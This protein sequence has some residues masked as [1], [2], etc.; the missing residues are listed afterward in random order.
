MEPREEATYTY[1]Q[2]IEM[3]TVTRSWTLNNPSGPIPYL[4][5][6]WVDYVSQEENSK[7]SKATM[8]KHKKPHWLINL[9]MKLRIL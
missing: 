4:P 9:L 3:I 7:A 6:M 1:R 5:V 8:P 2:M